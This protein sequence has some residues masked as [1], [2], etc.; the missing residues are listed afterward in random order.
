MRPIFPAVILAISLFFATTSTL[1]AQ[2]VRPVY[3]GNNAAVVPVGATTDQITELAGNLTPSAR[4]LNWQRTEFNA[5][6][7]FGLNTFTGKE[8]G[9]G[10][11]DPKQFNPK[12]FD[13]RQ[14]VRTFREAGMK[15]V[16]LTARHH[17]G[18]CLWPTKTTGYSVAASPWSGG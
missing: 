11:D 2:V 16:I 8:W 7:H 18:F 4:Q 3:I 5:F 1:T 6:I 15:M 12:K 9:D 13:A 14:W 10:N 17:D